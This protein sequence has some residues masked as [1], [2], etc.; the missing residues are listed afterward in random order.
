[1]PRTRTGEEDT[2]S[3]APG[4]NSAGQYAIFGVIKDAANTWTAFGNLAA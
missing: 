1:M 2:A 3:Y 4:L